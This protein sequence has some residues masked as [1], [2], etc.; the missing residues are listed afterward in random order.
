MM[1]N[2]VLFRFVGGSALLVGFVLTALLVGRSPALAAGNSNQDAGPGMQQKYCQVYVQALASNLN[3][4][5]AQLAAANKNA[6]QTTVQQAY[7]DGSMTQAQETSRLDQINQLGPDPCADLA[8]IAAAH[9]AR[10]AAARKAVVNAVASELK[11]SP[12]A[13]DGKLSSGQTVAQIAAAQHVS[14]K[15]VNA[16]YLNAVR[17]QLKTAVANGTMTQAQSDKA[18]SAIQSAVSRGEYPLLHAHG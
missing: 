11:L 5:V 1:R 13:L 8:R 16:A 6:L 12:A 3:V 17:S 4:S 2:K 15:S 9:R 14:L 7:T 18:Y 10:L